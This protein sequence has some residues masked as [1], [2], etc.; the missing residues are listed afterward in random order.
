MPVLGYGG[1]SVLSIRYE[2][3]PYDGRK[4]INCRSENLEGITN[5][6]HLQARR[7]REVREMNLPKMEACGNFVREARTPENLAGFAVAE[8]PLYAQPN[9]SGIAAEI[10]RRCNEYDELKAR[11]A[12]LEK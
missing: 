4:L 2:V 10:V 3:R 6:A 8:I 5:Q 11:V 12:E 1:K 9:A 7:Q